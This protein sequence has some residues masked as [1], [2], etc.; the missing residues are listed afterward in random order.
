MEE[1]LEELLRLVQNETLTREQIIENITCR[2]DNLKATNELRYVFDAFYVSKKTTHRMLT[3]LQQGA[4]PND[5]KI[6]HELDKSPLQYI[7]F[8]YRSNLYSNEAFELKR[9]IELL[10]SFDADPN[11]QDRFGYTALHELFGRNPI[12][13]NPSKKT[14]VNLFQCF[15]LLIMHDA[16]PQIGN[17]LG[18]TPLYFA[19]NYRDVSLLFVK[20]IFVRNRKRCILL[21]FE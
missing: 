19:Y 4:N 10:L 2:R 13:R 1:I 16:D 6:T 17:E 5:F 12:K 15:K 9:M 14:P 8:W 18:R 7:C 21:L 3:L 20:S 11:T